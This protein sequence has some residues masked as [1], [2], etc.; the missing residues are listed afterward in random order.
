MTKQLTNAER[1][2]GEHDSEFISLLLDRITAMCA[3]LESNNP[4][5]DLGVLVDI[6]RDTD[7]L[8]LLLGKEPRNVL[9]ATDD[10]EELLH[11]EY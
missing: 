1:Q 9:V 10:Y 2:R 6:E 5:A 7:V 11:E 4:S 3:E 8:R